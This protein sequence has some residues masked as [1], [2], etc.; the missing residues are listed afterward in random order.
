MR[1]L[2]LLPPSFGRTK[3]S[4]PK[5]TCSTRGAIRQQPAYSVEKLGGNEVD[6]RW[7]L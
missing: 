7:I 3:T 4:R 2:L 1:S 5:V 6:F